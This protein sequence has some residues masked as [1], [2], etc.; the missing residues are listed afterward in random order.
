MIC[1]DVYVSKWIGY[2]QKKTC[3]DY[4][5]AGKVNFSHSIKTE[6]VWLFSNCLYS[7]NCVHNDWKFLWCVS[8]LKSEWERKSCSLFGIYCKTPIIQQN[9]YFE[10]TMVFAAVLRIELYF[11]SF[12]S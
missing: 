5:S 3:F 12:D 8:E 11:Q 4:T 9:I 2:A 10:S 6:F 7:M 1:V